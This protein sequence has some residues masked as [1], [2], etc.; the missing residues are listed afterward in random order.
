MAHDDRLL[1]F[2]NAAQVPSLDPV[3]GV[4]DRLLATVGQ[5]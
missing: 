4:F 2:S 3:I 5:Y 1:N